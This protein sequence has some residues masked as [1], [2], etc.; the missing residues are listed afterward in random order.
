[1]LIA[2]AKKQYNCAVLAKKAGV[3]R[4]TISYIRNGKSCKPDIAGK[5]AIALDLSVE[6][7]I[8]TKKEQTH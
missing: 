8:E 3:S 7:L 2:M 1:M 6:E 5:L 4:P